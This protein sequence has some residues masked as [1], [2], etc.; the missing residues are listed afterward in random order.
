M[1]RFSSKNAL[2]SKK[3]CYKIS[4][5]EICQRQICKAFI[6][7]SIPTNMVGSGLPLLRE[8]VAETGPLRQTR[9]IS[10]QYSLVAPQP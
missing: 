8:N 5:Y 10:H 9:L 1:V 2:L 7:L 4:V 6:G 3:G